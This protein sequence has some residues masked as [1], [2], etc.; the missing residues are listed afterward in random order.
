MSKKIICFDC[1][2]CGNNLLFRDILDPSKCFLESKFCC[3]KKYSF[4]YRTIDPNDQTQI[5]RFKEKGYRNLIWDENDRETL[6]FVEGKPEDD[7]VIVIIG[8][9][10]KIVAFRYTCKAYVAKEKPKEEKE[11]KNETL[12]ELSKT[13]DSPREEPRKNKEKEGKDGGNHK[14]RTFIIPCLLIFAY[15]ILNVTMFKEELLMVVEDL[16]ALPTPISLIVGGHYVTALLQNFY[17]NFD[18]EQLPV[19]YTKPTWSDFYFEVGESGIDDCCF[20]EEQDYSIECVNTLGTVTCIQKVST[21][22]VGMCFIDVSNR[23]EEGGVLKL[24]EAKKGECRIIKPTG[25]PGK[26]REVEIL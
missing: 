7:L 1:K 17:S 26:E 16:L 9:E 12:P 5:R 23:G 15:V 10:V 8:K 19:C 25:Y 11:M 21:K 6:T 24:R 14:L 13:E 2:S 4:G 20:V 18:E 22:G 3:S